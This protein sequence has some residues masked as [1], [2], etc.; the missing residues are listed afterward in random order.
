MK[1]LA[2]ELN[3]KPRAPSFQRPPNVS[4]ASI[5]PSSFC[6]RTNNSTCSASLNKAMLL[7]SRQNALCYRVWEA[8]YGA[9]PAIAN[10]SA[11]RPSSLGGRWDSRFLCSRASRHLRFAFSSPPGGR[12]PSSRRRLRSQGSILRGLRTPRT[13]HDFWRLFTKE[14]DMKNP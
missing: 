12:H 8:D 1:H 5:V 4:S 2:P 14:E 3:T 11:Q 10:V 9:N 13:L 6:L 7:H